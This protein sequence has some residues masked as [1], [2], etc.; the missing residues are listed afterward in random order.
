MPQLQSHH[1]AIIRYYACAD[2]PHEISDHASFWQL[3]TAMI[4]F[5]VYDC[6]TSHML[7]PWRI[8]AVNPPDITFRGFYYH[9]A[10]RFIEGG[11][12]ASWLELDS[13]FVGTSKERLDL[14]DSNLR[15]WM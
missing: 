6:T 11:P 9:E 7:L 1:Y 10:T 13:T 12:V 4:N 5:T 3:L 2:L 8:H 15:Q 14:V